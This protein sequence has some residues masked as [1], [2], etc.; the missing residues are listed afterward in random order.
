MSKPFIELDPELARKAV[1]GYENVLVGE[2]KKLDVFYRQ[3]TCLRCHG[4]VQKETVLGHAF[5][6]ADT[7]VARS[8][9]RC[10][11]CRC[12]FDPHSGLVLELGIDG[13]VE[14]TK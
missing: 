5:A 13:P 8:V 2:Q 4:S 1:E 7:L 6:D 3:F 9:L 10:T 12:L 14:V 11:A